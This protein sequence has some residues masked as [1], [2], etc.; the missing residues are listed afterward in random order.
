MRECSKVTQTIKNWS[1]K[2]GS[3][4]A[5]KQDNCLKYNIHMSTLWSEVSIGF[6]L[7][8]WFPAGRLGNTG[9]RSLPGKNR[10]LGGPPLL[11]VLFPGPLR[12]EQSALCSLLPQPQVLPTMPSLPWGMGCT[13]KRLARQNSSWRCF[14]SGIW[15]QCGENSYYM[16]TKKLLTK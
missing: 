2:S 12:H 5:I 14:L 16:D 4:S 8:H 1:V 10:T 15:L 13:L 3:I 7:N 9:K 11:P 6:C